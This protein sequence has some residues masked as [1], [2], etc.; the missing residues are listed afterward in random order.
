MI[1][2]D[3]DN[4]RTFADS[5]S[6]HELVWHRDLEDRKLEV[7]GITDWLIQLDNKLPQTINNTVIPKNMWHRLIKGTDNL[8]IKIHKLN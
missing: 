5:I 1:Y 8:V 7:I 2:V 3:D 6:E 4:I